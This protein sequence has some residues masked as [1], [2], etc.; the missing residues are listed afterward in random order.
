M[1]S[2][3]PPVGFR[4]IEK[5]GEREAVTLQWYTL[6]QPLGDGWQQVDVLGEMLNN[7]AVGIGLCRVSDDA[8]DVITRREV[9]EFLLQ[10]LIAE[11]FTMVGSQHDQ[12]R[13]PV[14]GFSKVIPHSSKLVIDLAD[15]AEVLRS[16]SCQFVCISWC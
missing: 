15:H 13:L 6:A 5:W 10:T 14:V 9:A 12:C 7:P 8:T 1:G 11:L 4:S 2:G 3:S 16:K